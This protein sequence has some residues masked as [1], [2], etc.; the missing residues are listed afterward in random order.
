MCHLYFKECVNVAAKRL[1]YGA[2]CKKKLLFQVFTV[3]GM[4]RQRFD[5]SLKTLL[6]GWTSGG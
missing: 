5:A 2:H 6:P 3:R 4:L 1:V